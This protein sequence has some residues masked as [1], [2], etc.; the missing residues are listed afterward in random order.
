MN[1]EISVIIG[2]NLL[3]TVHREK[4]LGVETQNEHGLSFSVNGL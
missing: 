4:S 2:E 3:R 1:R